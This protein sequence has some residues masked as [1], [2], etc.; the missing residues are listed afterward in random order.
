MD[1]KEYFSSKSIKGRYQQ[2]IAAD[3]ARALISFCEQEPEFAQA[4]EES[5]KTFQDCL[6]SVCKNVG[7]GISDFTVFS[8][9]VKFY[10]STAEVHFNMT[11]DLI[12]GNDRKDPPITM[13][14]HA[15]ESLSVSLDEL[16]DF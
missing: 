8:R 16:L 15:S 6:D 5:G 12:G 13:T 10:F 4:V 7:S 11:I 14:Q 1:T 3:T 2:V 9:A